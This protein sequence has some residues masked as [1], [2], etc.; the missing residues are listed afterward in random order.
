M[1]TT[2]EKLKL[3]AKAYEA[4]EH[5][6]Y[7]KTYNHA[8]QAYKTSL[9]EQ[10]QHRGFASDFAAYH[11][12]AATANQCARMFVV[13]RVAEY[14]NGERLPAIKDYFHTQQSAFMCAAIALEYGDEV[15]RAWAEFDLNE[16]AALDYCELV[17]KTQ[18][19]A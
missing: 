4:L 7:S 14:I 15:R 10:K 8:D 9:G 13:R 18:V 3:I 6:F 2:Q 12:N 19:P 1:K 16:L 17:G 11:P 5:V